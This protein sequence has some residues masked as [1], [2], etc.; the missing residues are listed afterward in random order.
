M[1]K[2]RNNFVQH[3]LYEVIRGGTSPY[4]YLWS[5]GATEP[6]LPNVPI[7]TYTVTVTDANNCEA[8]S[9]A[10]ISQPDSIFISSQINDISCFG[11]SDGS[12]QVEIDSYNFV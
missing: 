1:D 11:Y 3:T 6:E 5:N 8:Y 9:G 10:V 2:T 7:G 12:I 4:N